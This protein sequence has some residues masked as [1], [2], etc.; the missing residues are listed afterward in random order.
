[1]FKTIYR[2]TSGFSTLLDAQNTVMDVDGRLEHIRAEM[3]DT[4]RMIEFHMSSRTWTDID[5]AND[6]Q[7]LWYLR[8]DV[9]RMLCAGLGEEVARGHLDEITEMFR[10][11]VPETQMPVVHHFHD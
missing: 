10:G 4:L 8:S 9:M 3:L 2:I 1:M 7:T 11:M 5:R 6:A